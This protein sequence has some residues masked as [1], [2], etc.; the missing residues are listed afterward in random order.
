MS[1]A[2]K[3]PNKLKNAECKKGQLSN[4]PPIPYV[5]ETNIIMPKE[6]LQVYMVKLSDN[7]HINM[8]IYSPGNNEEYLTHIVAVLHVIKQRRL[9]SRCRKLKKAVLR[10]SKMLKNLLEAAG[11]RDTVLTDV[12][13]TACKVEIEQ[14]Q[15]LLEGS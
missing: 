10:Q 9:D 1:A 15:Q 12:D 11:S 2:L 5:P 6:D 8:H 7:S 4:W 3:S 14:T 13:V